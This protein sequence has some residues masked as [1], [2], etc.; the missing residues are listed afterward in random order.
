MWQEFWSVVGPIFVLITFYSNFT[1]AIAIGPSV[2]LDKA[3]TY[4]TQ[5]LITNTGRVPVYDLTFSCLFGGPTGRMDVYRLGDDSEPDDLAPVQRLAAGQP[6]TK[7][8]AT[9]SDVGGNNQLTFVVNFKWPLIGYRDS[10]T[11]F[12]E[13]KEGREGHFLL[14]SGSP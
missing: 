2:N 12:F 8:C 13:I 1:P 14:P 7:A 10:R 3:Q 4:S 5:I 11:A 6:I 9:T